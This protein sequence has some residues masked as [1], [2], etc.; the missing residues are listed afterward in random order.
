MLALWISKPKQTHLQLVLLRHLCVLVLY[1]D[2][3]FLLLL[4]GILL[5]FLYG[6]TLLVSCLQVHG[7]QIF[8]SPAAV[9]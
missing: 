7:D 3:P 4:A 2:H 6:E 8:K 5:L 1:C 9:C